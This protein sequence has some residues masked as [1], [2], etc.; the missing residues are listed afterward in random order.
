MPATPF[1]PD[2]PIDRTSGTPLSSQIAEPLAHL[3]PHTALPTGPRPG[4]VRA[5]PWRAWGGVTGQGTTRAWRAGLGQGG[6]AGGE[7]DQGGPET[8][9]ADNRVAYRRGPRP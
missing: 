8:P 2:I 1:R 3:I 9:G 6:G 5:I 7:L 4:G